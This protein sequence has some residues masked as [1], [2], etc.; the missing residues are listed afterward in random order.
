MNANTRL[1]AQMRAATRSLLRRNPSAAPQAVPEATQAAARQ[2]GG[3]PF[4]DMLADLSRLGQ[5]GINPFNVAPPA[6]GLPGRFIDGGY[7]IY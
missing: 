2:T 5:I 1:L 4:T 7:T 6:T 3:D